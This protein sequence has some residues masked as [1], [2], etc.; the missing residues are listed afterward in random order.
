M[1]GYPTT[2][3]GCID[4][5]VR[6]HT[7]YGTLPKTRKGYYSTA[8]MIVRTFR[9]LGRSD[10]PY[11]WSEEDFTAIRQYWADS[12]LEVKTRKDYDFVL[13]SFAK[14]FG[15]ATGDKTKTRFPPDS[16]P[17]VRWLT[18]EEVHII[19]N[20]PMSE[21]EEMCI[22]L[23]LSMGLRRVEVIRAKLADIHT[24]GY[25]Y[26]AVD[27]KGHKMRKVPF[28]WSTAFILSRWMERRNALVDRARRKAKR[29]NRKFFDSGHLIVYERVGKLLPYS[30][31][32]PNGFDA[33]VVTAVGVRCGIHFDNHTLR[34]TFGRELYYK[35]TEPIDL[36]TLSMLY[37]H[38]SIDQTVSYIGPDPRRMASGILK[39]S[40]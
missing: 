31:L 17:N 7:K 40:Y 1:S 26:I 5:W 38:D 15:N 27:G 33:A 22:H 30:E 20:T 21:L 25:P 12:G 29:N 18:L 13:R 4:S 8:S 10:L 14:F 6:W 19:I 36:L 32:H 23:M 16:R 3:E 35:D 37:G 11:N 9:S 24:E 28:N 34:R 39:T 2:A